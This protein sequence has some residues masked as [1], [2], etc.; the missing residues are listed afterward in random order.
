[1]YCYARM[2]GGA[3]LK[4]ATSLIKIRIA[5]ICSFTAHASATFFISTFEI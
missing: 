4:D 1:M 2:R 3:F 5:V